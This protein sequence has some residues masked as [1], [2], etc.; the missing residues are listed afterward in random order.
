MPGNVICLLDY[1]IVRRLDD[2]LKTF[3]TDLLAAIVNQDVDEVVTLL[4]FAGDV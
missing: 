1:G 3:L 2:T 4:L